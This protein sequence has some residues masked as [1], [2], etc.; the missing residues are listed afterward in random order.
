MSQF[1]DLKASLDGIQ[2]AVA[3]M[4][5]RIDTIILGLGGPDPD[6]TPLLA[7]AQAI[8]DQLDAFHKPEEPP[9]A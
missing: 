9:V 4:S 2:A 6:I 5:T 7:E 3:D 1:D 8:K